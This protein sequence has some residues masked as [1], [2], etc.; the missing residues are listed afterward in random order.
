MRN[1]MEPKKK[2]SERRAERVYEKP[3]LTD[4]DRRELTGLRLPRSIWRRTQHTWI[5]AG[6][7]WRYS[8][9]LDVLG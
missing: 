8:L 7:N 3:L 6:A 5:G 1:T 2:Q 4:Q 9:E